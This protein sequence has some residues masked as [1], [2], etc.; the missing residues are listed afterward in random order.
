MKLSSSR[1]KQGRQWLDQTTLLR[2]LGR[3]LLVRWWMLAA[4]T[5]LTFALTALGTMMLR[6]VYSA[7]AT[8]LLKKERFD[9]PVSPEQ[10]IVTGQPDRHLTEEEINSEV[11]ILRSRTLLEAVVRKLDLDR[12]FQPREDGAVRS[13]LS[14][15]LPDD[16][17]SPVVRAQMKLQDDLSID[18][19]KKS[20]VIRVSCRAGD[21]DLAAII[22]NTLCVLYQEQHIR[23]RQNDGTKN[24][25]EQ[26]AQSLRDRLAEQEAVMQRLSPLPGAQ[27]L[28]Q[29]IEL[30]LRQLNEYEVAWQS[31]RTALVESE[32][33]LKSL[34]EQL[35]RE[36]GQLDSEQRTSWRL[37]PDTIKATLFAL[38]LRR[39][40]LLGRY[41]PDH[42]LVREVEK[43]LAQARQMV[44]QVEKSSSESV[45]VVTLNPLRQ[46]LT[47]ALASERSNFASLR[48]KER[49][50]AA[51]VRQ[52]QER[53]RELGA[54][55]YE[56]RRLDREREL[57]DAAYQN[58]AKKGE[59]SRISTALDRQGII[60]VQVIEPARAPFKALSPNVPFNLA[61]G[62]LG[63]LVAALATVF[64]LEYFNPTPRKV[65]PARPVGR[66]AQAVLLAGSVRGRRR[67]L[68]EPD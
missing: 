23:L 66:V 4:I 11:E 60:N 55:G 45:R 24:F 62:L 46:R 3:V 18:P 38:E 65:R 22:V 6:P 25:F 52:A 41:R 13:V 7:S 33:R 51:T 63:G 67:D 57:A 10:T 12:E 19:V 53:L 58:Y 40:E 61:L 29:Q 49:V 34:S 44:E 20:N 31:T 14:S 47:D 21:R 17:L 15:L 54:R 59:E 68:S 27:L 35:S 2:D 42:R 64:T 28:N 16:A 50:L 32:A 37:A 9:A 30:Q 26:Q 5:L 1:D 48:E 39:T 8:I 56:Q 43:E 36:P